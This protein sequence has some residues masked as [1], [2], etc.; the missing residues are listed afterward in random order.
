MQGNVVQGRNIWLEP[1][2]AVLCL[3]NGIE[4]GVIGGIAMLALLVSGSFWRGKCA[5]DPW[6]SHNLLRENP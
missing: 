5:A 4:A 3:L 2:R 6:Q 1:K